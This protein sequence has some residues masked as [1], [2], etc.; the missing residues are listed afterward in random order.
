VN[1]AETRRASEVRR[2]QDKMADIQRELDRGV[3]GHNGAL[4]PYLAERARVL[5]AERARLA[6]TVADLEAVAGDELTERF[7][8]E[9][10]PVD[11]VSLR[12]SLTHRGDMLPSQKVVSRETH[13]GYRTAEAGP[14]QVENGPAGWTPGIIHAPDYSGYDRQAG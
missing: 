1:V 2:V 5:A 6:S 12:D 9:A 14:V 3:H 4:D 10:K 8:P 13:P 7:V 11:A